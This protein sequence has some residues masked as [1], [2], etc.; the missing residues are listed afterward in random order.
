MT[1]DEMVLLPF[2]SCS[3]RLLHGLSTSLIKV[4]VGAGRSGS[5]GFLLAFTFL[6]RFIVEVN[7]SAAAG[8]RRTC[9]HRL[10]SQVSLSKHAAGDNAEAPEA[11]TWPRFT[12]LQQRRRHL[13]KTRSSLKSP[14]KEL[15]LMVFLRPGSFPSSP[16]QLDQTVDIAVGKAAFCFEIEPVPSDVRGLGGGAGL[17]VNYRHLRGHWFIIFKLVSA[18]L[19]WG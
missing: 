12:T 13:T 3:I 4:A 7:V 1:A 2:T 6:T 10:L 14:N 8:G 9:V 19:Q 5:V 18:S 16:T 17:E 11:E 15:L